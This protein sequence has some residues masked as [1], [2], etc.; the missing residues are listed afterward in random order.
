MSHLKTP[1]G[2]TYVLGNIENCSGS[3]QLVA[4]R[5]T[6]GE[7]ADGCDKN[8]RKTARGANDIGA[9]ELVCFLPRITPIKFA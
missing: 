3:I 6:Y 7:M 9:R 8:S 4:S 1:D 5:N 2:Q